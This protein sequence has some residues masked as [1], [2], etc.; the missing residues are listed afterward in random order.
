MAEDS[1]ASGETD[2]SDG[3]GGS[4]DP[5]DSSGSSRSGGSIGSIGSLARV[6][7]RLYAAQRTRRVRWGL[8]A[9]AAVVGVG[10]ATLHWAGLLV[11]GALVGLSAPTFRRALVAGL[12]FAGLVLAVA[13]VQFSVAGVL[14]E[15]LAMGQIVWVSV[16]TAVGLALVGAS[17][18]GLFP[19]ATVES[20]RD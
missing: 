15:V 2:D 1:R 12:G 13:S 9:V 20:R 6:R 3:S 18:R 10:L 16:G 7:D 17:V 4:G 5:R 8:A 11:G 14:D 19:D